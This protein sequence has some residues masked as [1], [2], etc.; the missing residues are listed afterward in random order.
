MAPAL[1][2]L[3]YQLG[4]LALFVVSFFAWPW[5]RNALK[6]LAATMRDGAELSESA[7]LEQLQM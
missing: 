7:T 3:W 4:C 2:E 1:P 6:V 5:F